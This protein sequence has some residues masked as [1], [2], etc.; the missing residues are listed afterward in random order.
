MDVMKKLQEWTLLWVKNKDI[1]ARQ[2]I[3]L[4]EKA[5]ELLITKTTGLQRYVIMPELGLLKYIA[6]KEKNTV[7]V[8]F[9]THTNINFLLK[10]WNE[11]IDQPQLCVV[12]VNPD[13]RTDQ[14]WAV[15]PFT[16]HRIADSVEKGIRAMFENVEE[17]K[18]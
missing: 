1:L 3:K 15:F 4:E 11:I 12:F 17:W 14:K 2:I 9:N 8:T 7:I 18:G 16:H 10:Q 5:G 13:S 6:T